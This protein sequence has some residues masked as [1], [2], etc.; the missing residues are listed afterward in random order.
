MSFKLLRVELNGNLEAET[1]QF[2]ARLAYRASSM[3]C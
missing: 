2:E 3:S 1:D